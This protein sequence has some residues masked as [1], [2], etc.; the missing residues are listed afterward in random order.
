MLKPVSGTRQRPRHSATSQFPVVQAIM[1][2]ELH[3][4]S[5]CTT[6]VGCHQC[7]QVNKYCKWDI[8]MFTLSC[9]LHVNRYC[10]QASS[11][12]PSTSSLHQVQANG[13]G[14]CKTGR[15]HPSDVL[16]CSRDV[17][18]SAPGPC[19]WPWRLQDIRKYKKE[20][21]ESI[22]QHKDVPDKKN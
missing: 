16:S 6:K 5:V 11:S 12:R 7:L 20:D 8:T 2:I 9:S 1:K 4:F 10:K 14:V 19:Q 22:D 15:A 18:I 17:G 13:L 3:R 21:Y